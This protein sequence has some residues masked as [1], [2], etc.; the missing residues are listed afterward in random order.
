MIRDPM[1][2]LV[3]RIAEDHAIADALESDDATM[4]AVGAG[5]GG[6]GTWPLDAERDAIVRLL[7]RFDARRIQCELASREFIMRQ[8]RR[9]AGGECSLC[10]VVLD[11]RPVAQFYPSPTLMSLTWAYADH[12]EFDETWDW[13]ADEWSS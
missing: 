9:T 13:A 10:V 4:P 12:S 7:R 1:P 5:H 3:A 2:F 11:D 8:H 6:E